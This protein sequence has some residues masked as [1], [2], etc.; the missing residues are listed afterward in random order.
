MR[1]KTIIAAA[2]MAAACLG[3]QAKTRKALYVIMDGV[4]REFLNQTRPATI[5]DIAAH[6][7][8][9]DAYAGGEVGAISE[10]P[11]ISAIGYTNILTGTWMNKHNVQGNSDIKTNYNYWSIFRIAKSQKR[12]VTTALFSSWSD[13][14][15]LLIGEG[16]EE[17]GGLKI[18]YVYDGY[19]LDTIRYPHKPRELHVYD[20]DSTV[21]RRAAECIRQKAPDLGWVYLWYTDDAFHMTGYSTFSDQYLRRED[22]MLRQIYDAIEYREK[23]FDEEWLLIVT[24]DH[25]REEHGFGHGGQSA[26]ER[27]IWMVSNRRDMN[28]QWGSHALSQV[29]INPSICRFMGFDVP[30]DVEWEQDGIPF[31][32]PADISSLTTT[33]FDN[34]VILGWDTIHATGDNAEIYISTTNNYRQGGRDEWR[35]VGTT[36]ASARTFTVDL[37]KWPHSTEYKFVVATPSNHVTRWFKRR[38]SNW[39]P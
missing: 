4:S 23:N 18:D 32:G 15:T 10:T 39:K 28:A 7:S 8:Y 17:T 29:D 3:T 36:K 37:D 14:R 20:Y 33:A 12:P 1:L 38:D 26:G 34:K 21:C 31:Y 16:R 5:F 2:I 30:R 9:A 6:G 35:H 13:N 19:D 22:Q 25:G 11:T 27:G 24:T